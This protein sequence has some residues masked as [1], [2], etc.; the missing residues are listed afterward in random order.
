MM[1]LK[2]DATKF[3][4][5]GNGVGNVPKPIEPDWGY[6]RATDNGE[7]QDEGAG[8]RTIAD[9]PTNAIAESE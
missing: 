4:A 9:C 5:H 2:I 8:R 7:V 3:Q 1:K 6:A